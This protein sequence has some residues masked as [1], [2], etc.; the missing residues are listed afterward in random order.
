MMY[1]INRID[2]TEAGS[3]WRSLST[4]TSHSA[5]ERARRP[6]SMPD[7]RIV[8]IA[9]GCIAASTIEPALSYPEFQTFSEKSGRTT[10][11]AMCHTNADGPVGERKGQIGKLNEE[12]L[13]RLN[14]ARTALQPGENVD[15]PILN[16]FGNYIIKTVGKQKVLE[17][18]KN[19]E[20]L[21]EALGPKHDLDDD[22]IPDAR[23]FKDGT[24][25]LNKFHGDAFA[26]F[27]HNLSRY[28]GDVILAVLAVMLVVFGL[29]NLIKALETLTRKTESTE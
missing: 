2:W 8:L 10:N 26:L 19:P 5:P 25:P 21:V 7:L 22:G 11:C 4:G 3:V 14:K 20:M 15:S 17:A 28:R 13:A 24:D 27:T 18:R 23:E 1:R 16:D 29:I 6:V 9:A 12:E